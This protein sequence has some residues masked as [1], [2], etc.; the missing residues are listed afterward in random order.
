M[1]PSHPKPPPLITEFAQFLR[2]NMLW[3]LLP[4]VL[5][6]L[7]FLALIL[8]SGTSSTPFIYSTY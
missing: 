4:L 5:V 6:L 8:I 7:L 1:D 2:Q 3:W